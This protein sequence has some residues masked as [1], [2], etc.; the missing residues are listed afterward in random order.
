VDGTNPYGLPTVDLHLGIQ[1]GG[2]S[3]LSGAMDDVRIWQRPAP[4]DAEVLAI[5][6]QSLLGYP[7]VLNW[8][9]SRLYGTTAAAAALGLGRSSVLTG[10]RY[11]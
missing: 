10:R 6:I 1:S 11:V 2:L 9:P 8:A 3:A 5:Y 7:D 4:T